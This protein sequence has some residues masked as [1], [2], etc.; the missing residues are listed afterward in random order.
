MESLSNADSTDVEQIV[1]GAPPS[2]VEFVVT[3]NRAVASKL[4]SVNTV[5]I[6]G[7]KAR[8]ITTTGRAFFA[9]T[10]L[11]RFICRLQLAQWAFL[12]DFA[13]GLL[14]GGSCN[15]AGKSRTSAISGLNMDG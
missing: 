10:I 14:V 12:Q 2:Q 3:S 13:G 5:Q 4:S 11:H 9:Q 8:R 6:F 7:I 15:L 1:G